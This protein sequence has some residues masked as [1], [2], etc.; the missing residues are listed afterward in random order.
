M[1]TDRLKLEHSHERAAIA[2]RLDGSVKPNY[3]RDFVY[4]GIDGAIT[5]FAVVA[6][7]IGASLSSNIILIL[8]LANLLADG[9]SMAASNYSGTKTVT[10]EYKR[11]REIEQRHI[12]LAA[13]GEREEVRQLMARKGLS[14]EALEEAVAAIT[15]DEARWIEF[16]LQEEYGFA[17][18]EPNPMKAAS[19]T[20][21]AFIICGAI[22]L[23]PFVLGL[24]SSFAISTS[25][26]ALVFFM[27]GAAKSFWS[28]APW[29]RSGGETLLIGGVAASL[30][31]VVGYFLHGLVT[32]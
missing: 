25:M 16:M 30:A 28:L 5:T 24:S 2:R 20:F 26:T 17:L 21:L 7:V 9:F 27:I 12:R 14:G 10:D 4:G 11:T 23:L 31:Y 18:T 15:S 3:I 19:V 6:G 1:E 22:P 13:E 8:G 29:W 32:G